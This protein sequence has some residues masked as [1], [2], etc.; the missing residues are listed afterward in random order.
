MHGAAVLDD[1]SWS[2]SLGVER[3]ECVLP[4]DDR[5]VNIRIVFGRLQI[6][7][8]V[9]RGPADMDVWSGRGEYNPTL[10]KGVI[11]EGVERHH[12]GS[13][14]MMSRTIIEMVQIEKLTVHNRHDEVFGRLVAESEAEDVAGSALRCR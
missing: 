1:Q 7:V 11:V 4:G 8:L 14:M 3:N 6:L 2:V 9:P 5:A 13:L 12:D 10:L